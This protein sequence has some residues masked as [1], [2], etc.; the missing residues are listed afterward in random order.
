MS[1][2][3][4]VVPWVGDARWTRVKQDTT[5]LLYRSGWDSLENLE[6]YELEYPKD[7]GERLVAFLHP[8]MN[9][10]ISMTKLMRAIPSRP[11]V[12]K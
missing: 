2:I 3:A 5:S 9:L 8:K 4:C 6:R 1:T 11:Q 7:S 10:D 12:Q